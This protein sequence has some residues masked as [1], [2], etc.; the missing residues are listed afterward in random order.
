MLKAKKKFLEIWWMGIFSENMG[1]I[2]MTVSEKT[3]FTE[4]I[5]GRR[6]DG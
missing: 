5:D 1:L 3:G 4:S 2:F 6:T